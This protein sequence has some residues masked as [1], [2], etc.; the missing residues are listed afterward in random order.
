MIHRLILYLCMLVPGLVHS[1]IFFCKDG[2]A[3][4]ISEA[5][6]EIIKAQNNKCTGVLDAATKNVTFSM[7]IE[8]FNG[9][10]GELQ[11]EHFLENYMESDKYPKGEFKGKIIEDVDLNTNGTYMVRAKGS[12][13][14]HGVSKEQIVKVKLVVKDKIIEVDSKFEILLS[15]YNIKIPKIVSQKV[16]PVIQV[17]VKALLKPK[18]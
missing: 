14:I 1:Q 18:S 4:F 16:A 3:S 7:A 11:K 15:D 17:A 10:N 9:F 8:N 2:I 12:F 13:N 5:P 6:L